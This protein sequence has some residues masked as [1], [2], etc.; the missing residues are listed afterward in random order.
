MSALIDLLVV[1]AGPTGLAL[2][3]EAAAGGASV[4]LIDSLPQR[5][6]KSR[7]LVV[8]PR[9]LE[10]LAMRGCAQGLLDMGRRTLSVRLFAAGK[11]VASARMADLA[12]DDTPFPFLLFVSQ[13]ET[14]RALEERCQR[15]GVRTERDSRL[16]SLEQ[17]ADAAYATVRGPRGEERIHARYLAGCDGAHSAVRHLLDLGFTGAPYEQEFLL[18][19]VSADCQEA[20]GSVC[21]FLGNDGLLVLFPYREEGR[22]RLIASRRGVRGSEGEPTI[23]EVQAA[24]DLLA[25]VHLKI[26]AASW[27]ARFRLHHR[28]VDRYRVGRVFVAGDAAHIHSPAGGQGMN[29]GIQDAFNLGWKIALVTKGTSGAARP[30]LLDSYEAERMPVGKKLLGYTDRAFSFMASQNPL[31]IGLRNLAVPPAARFL[32]ASP[33]RRRRAFRFVSQLGIRYRHSPAVAGEQSGA[34]QPGDRAPDGPLASGTVHALLARSPGHHLLAFGLAERPV[35]HGRLPLE[36]HWLIDAPLETR[37]RFGLDEGLCLVR[38]DGYV[39]FKAP[40]AAFAALEAYLSS[41]S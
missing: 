22:Y 27:M 30:G 9:T 4:R 8:Q 35:A 38:P 12:I 6:D 37:K 25:R 23:T 2:A 13:V 14:E 31:V 32:L 19:D 24:A 10:L 11:L 3:S 34:L 7:A 18:A 26:G 29:T 16:V 41:W 20:G 5:S 33:E 40:G 21:F 15:L 1:G 28:A 36:A 39:A 17:D